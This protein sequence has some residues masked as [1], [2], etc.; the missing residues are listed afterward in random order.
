M[1]VRCC[2][3]GAWIGGHRELMAR[4]ANPPRCPREGWD[5]AHIWAE[6]AQNIHPGLGSCQVPP[7]QP[8]FPGPVS[9]GT[10]SRAAT[11][12]GE[13]DA[14]P[15]V[16]PQHGDRFGKWRKGKCPTGGRVA[17][18]RAAHPPPGPHMGT[19]LGRGVPVSPPPGAS[20]GDE[21]VPLFQGFLSCSYPPGWR[22]RNCF[23]P[24]W[25]IFSCTA[26]ILAL[27]QRRVGGP[28]WDG[29][30]APRWHRVGM[31]SHGGRAPLGVR[32]GF[33]TAG[34]GRFGSEKE[35]PLR[36][37]R[38][39]LR[40]ALLPPAF[41]PCSV[42]LWVRPEPPNQPRGWAPGDTP[43]TRRVHPVRG[44]GGPCCQPPPLAQLLPPPVSPL[45]TAPGALHAPSTP[46]TRG[47]HSQWDKLG[48]ARTPLG[49]LCRC[50]AGA[51]LVPGGATRV[52]PACLGVTGLCAMALDT[53]P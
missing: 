52:G 3:G 39:A 19:A 53:H 29:T 2:V 27:S 31:G 5:S 25:V 33:C 35:S 7:G 15:P 23:V 20:D 34:M 48:H 28:T 46:R 44:D 32:R 50:G 10:P 18:A 51:P 22:N 6:D 49:T 17:A 14:H 41:V 9:A 21:A 47:Q 4:T 37:C 43:S 13:V 12:I 36:R 30:R 26:Y 8:W 24:R 40:G 45:G 11:P 1:A 16:M 38:C 42:P